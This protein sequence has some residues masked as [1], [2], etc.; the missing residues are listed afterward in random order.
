VLANL[1][2]VDALLR[3]GPWLV[4]VF[5]FGACVGS[6]LNVVN[7]RM[8]RGMSLSQ[9]PSRCPTCGGRL[10]FFRENLPILGWVL[11]RGKC[12][13]CR[14]RIS[15]VYPL[16]ELAIAL[17]FAGLYVVLFMAG[18]QD[19][20]WWEVGGA[21]WSRQQFLF[22]WPAWMALAFLFA[23]L[24]SMT[25]IDARTFTIPIQIPTFVA[26]SAFVFWGL[27]AMMARHGGVG[28]ASWPIPGTGWPA[29]GA[30]IG[31]GLGVVVA[32]SL[33]ASGRLRP[34]FHDYEDFLK[35]GEV[36]AD[37]P[38][39]RREMGVELCYLAPILAGIVLGAVALSGLEG[40]PPRWMQAVGGSLLGWLVGGGIVWAI[41][42]LGTLAFGKEA[43]GLG[44]VHLLA[45]VGA[46]LGWF[47]PILIFF[48]APFLGL[49]WTLLAA[50]AGAFR[51][52]PWREL[53]YGPHLAVAT[54]AVFLARP[55]VSEGW[56]KIM[57]A[58]EMPEAGLV[59]PVDNSHD[60]TD[61][62]SAGP[63]SPG[64]GTAPSTE[65][66]TVR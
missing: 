66:T 47:E 9:P 45:A 15:P 62:G 1:G 53:P 19:T 8:P 56:R 46:V 58:V 61:S 44:D 27:E 20:W 54:V 35:E 43:M 59:V 29:T 38:H 37:Y 6:F 48:L 34:S 2:A 14:T 23:G 51:G 4:F 21:W 22:A 10:R 16:V 57:P 63:M 17:L 28:A 33:L 55:V 3:H 26:I 31:G 65:G 52:R 49:T 41:R 50:L 25:V 39:A 5:A 40:V 32:M 42:M 12:R 11:L 7:W 36:L 64:A 13:F 60:W 24:F 18:P 30:A